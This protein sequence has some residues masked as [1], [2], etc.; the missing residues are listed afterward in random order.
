MKIL[1]LI[2]LISILK[3]G[4]YTVLTVKAALEDLLHLIVY[5]YFRFRLSGSSVY[6]W[7]SFVPKTV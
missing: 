6:N 1:D 4:A 3:S 7:V 5:K 2:Q